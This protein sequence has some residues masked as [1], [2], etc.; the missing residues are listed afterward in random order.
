MKYLTKLSLN[1]LQDKYID[2]REPPDRFNPE[3]GGGGLPSCTLYN[4]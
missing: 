1:K 3:M 4:T 2:Y